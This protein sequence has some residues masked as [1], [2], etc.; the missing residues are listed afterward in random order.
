MRHIGDVSEAWILHIKK[1]PHRTPT[2]VS[3]VIEICLGISSPLIFSFPGDGSLK[4]GTRGVKGTEQVT[5]RNV[6]VMKEWGESA[7]QCKE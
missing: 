6:N 3:R 4:G 1:S 2:D 7:Q 5:G